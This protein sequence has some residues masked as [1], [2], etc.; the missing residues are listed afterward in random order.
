MRYTLSS[1]M[2]P[3]EAVDLMIEG[4]EVARHVLTEIVNKHKTPVIII[5]D[6][7]D[8]NIRGK[9]IQLGL[10]AC[11]GNIKRFVELV[12]DRSQW[13]VDEINKEYSTHKAVTNGASFWRN[14]H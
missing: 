1:E 10:A 12:F 8:M 6:L 5:L 3:E 14:L 13:L 2:S 9:Q 4:N 11:E 7:D